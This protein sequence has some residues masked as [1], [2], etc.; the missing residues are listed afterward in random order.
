MRLR[1]TQCQV[2][3]VTETILLVITACLVVLFLAL[4]SL[5][6]TESPCLAKL[7]WIFLTDIGN[8]SSRVLLLAKIIPAPRETRSGRGNLCCL[9]GVI[10]PSCMDVFTP[11]LL[12]FISYPLSC[13][14]SCPRVAN[15]ITTIYLLFQQHQSVSSPHPYSG[16]NLKQVTYPCGAVNV[17]DS[18]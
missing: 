3:T 13:T 10:S 7:E 4:N 11:I 2:K 18:L 1:L 8:E 12:L 9:L 5:V 16:E 14:G 17:N 6:S 15:T